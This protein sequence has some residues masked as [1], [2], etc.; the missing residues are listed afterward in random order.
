MVAFFNLVRWKNLLL[1]L[2]IQLLLKF[3]LFPSFN[4][5]SNLSLLQFILL[6]VSLICITAAGYIINDIFDLKSD[7]INKPEKV[8]V[9]TYFSEEKSQRLYKWI[10]F[11]G[12][13]TGI[14]LALNL[15]KPS[16]SLIFIGTS[17]LLYYYSKK[18]KPKPLIGNLL[19]SFLISLCI[20]IL[21]ILDIN[22]ANKSIDQN[23]VIS[24]FYMLATFAFFINLIREIVKDLE[25]IKGDYKLN[26]NTLPILLGRGRTKMI[27]LFLA[28][29]PIGLLVYII[30]KFSALYNILTF[31]LLFFSLLPM[32]FI[33]LK[34]KSAKS[35]KN[36]K[37]ISNYLKIIMLLGITS[38]LVI[39]IK[40]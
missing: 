6:L 38:L 8:F 28:L 14:G 23:I 29:F 36:Y 33:V 31:Y 32:L 9:G 34:I 16:F 4:I 12:I 39:S 5:V 18:L 24:I 35:I 13:I 15:N 2:Y 11:I 1:I 27:L 10:N 30:V 3:V 7:L 21:L 17:I 26:M 37:T 40:I 25:D 20:L 19:V 22:P